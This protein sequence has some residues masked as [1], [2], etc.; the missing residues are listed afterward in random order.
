PISAFGGI[1]AFNRK[2]DADVAKQVIEVFSE[3]IVAPDYDKDA[4]EIFRSKKNLRVLQIKGGNTTGRECAS[5]SL[6][7][8]QISGG[9]LVQDPDIHRLAVAD[10]NFV[11][12]RKPTSPEIKAMLFA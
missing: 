7:Y 11:T 4:I 3:V 8:K 10:L 1:A 5:S 12:A 2:V 9:F 6:E